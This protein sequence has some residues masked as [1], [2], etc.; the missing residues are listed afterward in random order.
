MFIVALVVRERGTKYINGLWN[1]RFHIPIPYAL[2][3][4]T[5]EE[6]VADPFQ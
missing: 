5:S 6:V 2:P 1:S 4:T 3:S